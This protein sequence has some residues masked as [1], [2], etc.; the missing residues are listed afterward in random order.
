MLREIANTLKARP[1]ATL[2]LA[3]IF[4]VC[5]VF[6]GAAI[7]WNASV[8]KPALLCA[9]EYADTLQPQFVKGREPEP[10]ATAEYTYLVRNTARY[11]CPYYGPD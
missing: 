5:G 11:E 2:I 4:A 1:A 10:V 6:I 9:G 8:A 7:E 3:F